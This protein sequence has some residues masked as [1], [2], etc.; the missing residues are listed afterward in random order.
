[1]KKFKLALLI[2]LF[3]SFAL[4]QNKEEAE[5]L[6]D[7]GVA[8]H[9][10]GDYE[11]AITRYDKALLLDKDNLLALAEKAFSLLSLQKYDE[12]ILYCQKA[13]EKHPAEKDLKSVYVTYGNAL[14]ALMKTDKAIALYE[15]GINKF[16]EY[17]QL[18]FNKGITLSSVK[19]IDEALQCFQKSAGLNPKHAGSNNALARLM[20]SQDKNIPAILAFCRFLIIEPQSK[21]AEENLGFLQ[22]IMKANVKQT[23]ENAITINLDSKMLDDKNKN[24]KVKENNFRSTELILSMDAALDFSEKNLKKTDVEQFIRKFE[25]ICASLKETKKDNFGFYWDYYVPYFTELAEKKL[26]EPFAYIAFASSDKPEISKWLENHK[27]EINKFYDWNK[28][29][30][31]AT[32]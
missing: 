4:A 15:E 20:Y 7:E 21:R 17:Y 11:G 25:T 9:D 26:I 5:K 1:M 6:V 23:G 27:S 10:K 3:S 13:I 24:G 28:G 16:P 18:Y 19:K 22:K 29:F 30:N 31:W 14:D 32:K 12:A 2:M 8:Y